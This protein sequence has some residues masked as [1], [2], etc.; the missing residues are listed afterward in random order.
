MAFIQQ[1][2]SPLVP[3]VEKLSNPPEGSN[4]FKTVFENIHS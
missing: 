1:L 2:P 3:E 4:E